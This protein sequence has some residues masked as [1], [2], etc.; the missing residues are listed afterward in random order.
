MATDNVQIST[1][2]GID[3]NSYTTGIINDNL[4]NDDFLKL[5]LE[6]L[7]SQDPTKPMDANQLL[8]NQLKMSQIQANNDM[9]ASLKALS[10]SYQTSILSNAVNMIG[11]VVENDEIGENGVNLSYKIASIE[12]QDGEVILI[13]NKIKGL[14][15][16]DNFILEDNFSKIPLNS[17]VRIY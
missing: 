3:G 2:V 5:Y 8:D 4:T 16:N 15:E 11:K 7:K 9:I 17:I 1:A 13:G 14:D 10:Q 12:Q 6:E